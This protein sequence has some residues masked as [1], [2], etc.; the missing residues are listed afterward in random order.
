MRYVQKAPDDIRWEIDRNEFA[1]AYAHAHQSICLTRHIPVVPRQKFRLPAAKARYPHLSN[2]RTT[3][4]ERSNDFQ[5]WAIH[6]DVGTRLADDETL[7]RWGAVARPL[8]GRIDVMFG[9]ALTTSWHL[10]SELPPNLGPRNLA[11][12]QHQR[13]PRQVFV[14]LGRGPDWWWPC[15]PEGPMCFVCPV[16]HQYGEL[17]GMEKEVKQENV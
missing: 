4:R 17:I 15:R 7:A 14:P 8:H 5:V 9:P 12:L 1:P 11:A 10:A 2:V 13:H 16:E 6:T 3:T